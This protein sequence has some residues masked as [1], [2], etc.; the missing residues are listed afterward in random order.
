MALAI[1][2]ILCGSYPIAWHTVHLTLG[3]YLMNEWYTTRKDEEMVSWFKGKNNSVDVSFM[4]VRRPL[5][6]SIIFIYPYVMQWSNFA[7]FLHTSESLCARQWLT[8]PLPQPYLRGTTYCLYTW[9]TEKF[10]D[11]SK[12]TATKWHNQGL[13]PNSLASDP[14]LSTGPFLIF[15]FL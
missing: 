12:F 15:I 8:S 1:V 11:S 7:F 2:L 13:V 5:E 3:I 10:S 9:A 6:F 14:T 4:A